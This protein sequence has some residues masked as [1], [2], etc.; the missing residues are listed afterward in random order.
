MGDK[1]QKNMRLEADVICMLEELAEGTGRD[2]NAMVE[3]LIR[4]AYV[5]PAILEQMIRTTEKPQPRE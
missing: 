3:Y 2:I 1:K 4:R 5:D